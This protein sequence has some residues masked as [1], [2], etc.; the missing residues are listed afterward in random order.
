VD[1]LP[2]EPPGKPRVASRRPE[3]S[4]GEHTTYQA[5]AAAAELD[6]MFNIS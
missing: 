6:N 3:S 2:S 4:Q 1:S 5:M